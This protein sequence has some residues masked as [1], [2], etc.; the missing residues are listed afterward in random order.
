MRLRTYFLFCVL[1]VSAS[2][3]TCLILEIQ[4]THVYSRRSGDDNTVSL[5][6]FMRAVDRGAAKEYQR[7]IDQLI[8]GESGAGRK[9]TMRMGER[10]AKS[11]LEKADLLR[12]E[13]IQMSREEKAKKERKRRKNSS[14]QSPP[15]S[16]Y[17]RDIFET[18][19][20][21][22]SRS[23]SKYFT[24]RDL[25][26]TLDEKLEI[27]GLDRLSE[28]ESKALFTVMDIDERGKIRFSD[29]SI[30]VGDVFFH[31]VVNEVKQ[32][33]RDLRMKAI[34][35]GD[36]GSVNEYKR[37]KRA[38]E[39]ADRGGEGTLTRRDFKKEL[40]SLGFTRYL[41][42]DSILERLV[43]RFDT[44]GND[45]IDYVEFMDFIHDEIDVNE[46]VNRE[47]S[48]F[49]FFNSFNLS[50]S[51]IHSLSPTH[52]R[53][54]TYSYARKGALVLSRVRSAL[55]SLARSEGKGIE[56]L[57]SQFD[58]DGNGVLSM[59]EFRQALRK[60]GLRLKED[61]VE[62]VMDVFD[63]DGDGEIDLREFARFVQERKKKG[64][65]G[66]YYSS[67]LCLL[68]YILFSL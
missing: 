3:L 34:S 53:R 10:K 5:V 27:P 23:S 25:R 11:I 47:V 41:L 32:A 8:E 55:R 58:E 64:R 2:F 37:L 59:S 17:L 18:Y 26:K 39:R 45:R 19:F 42:S 24:F 50:L 57:F 40:R 68:P 62:R 14:N 67:S 66:E 54:S 31:D 43:T 33:L 21:P 7:R 38:F 63:S 16:F 35:H 61:E 20:L 48:F 13:I 15:S 9:G 51:L 56:S 65:H 60:M 1:C 12:D 49:F 4:I 30:F 22:S 44:D 46:K 6:A 28:E 36:R 52:I 29:F